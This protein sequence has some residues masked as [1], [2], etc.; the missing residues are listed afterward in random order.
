MF[1]KVPEGGAAV[2]VDGLFVR[3][4]RRKNIIIRICNFSFFTGGWQ[5]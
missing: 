2:D 4:N 3:L 1:K 5:T